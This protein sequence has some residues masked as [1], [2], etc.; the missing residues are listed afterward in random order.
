VVVEYRGEFD[1]QLDGSTAEGAAAE[2]EAL[3]L[4]LDDVQFSASIKR[5]DS[6]HAMESSMVSQ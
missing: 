4:A 6:R 2:K 3:F 5:S 1:A